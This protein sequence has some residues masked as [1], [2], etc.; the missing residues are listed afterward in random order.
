LFLLVFGFAPEK[1][2]KSSANPQSIASGEQG[3]LSRI[4]DRVSSL[5]PAF[6]QEIAMLRVVARFVIVFGLIFVPAAQAAEFLPGVHRILFLGDSITYDGQYVDDIETALRLHFPERRFEIVNCGLPSETVSGLSEPGHA[7]GKFPRPDLHERLD[8]VLAKTKP[9][10]V[11]AC[12]GMNDGI[13][14]P[15]SEE[16]FEKFKAGMI[17]LHEKVTA[18]GMQIVHIT[19]PV[20]DPEPIRAKVTT[21][22]KADAGHP[23]EGYNKVL[24]RYSEWLVEQG[25]A[26]WR[27]IDL[28]GEMNKA[29]AERRKGDPKFTFCRDGVHPDSGGHW[30][31][32][33]AVLK[34]VGAPFDL[35]EKP[36]DENSKFAKVRKLVRER[37]RILTDAWLSETKHKRPMPPGLPMDEAKQ[38]AAETERRIEAIVREK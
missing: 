7:D 22:D 18:G 36:S 38:K 9:D 21:A 16:R 30:I 20:F 4:I 25:N 28:H 32:A 19:S 5:F 1:D 24:D 15:L 27:V 2:G 13:Y 35:E 3:G 8:R 37:G 23:Y 14:L 34:G 26:G 12:Y 10:L 29:L 31:V 6:L 33:R 11:L 17:K